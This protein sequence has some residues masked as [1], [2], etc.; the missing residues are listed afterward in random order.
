MNMDRMQPHSWRALRAVSEKYNIP[1]EKII[2]YSV[3][4][5]ALG[6]PDWL[7]RK[8][9]SALGGYPDHDYKNLK[10]KI[11]HHHHGIS[12]E[13]IVVTNGASEFFFH[14]TRALERKVALLTEPSFDLYKKSAGLQK[15]D[16][17]SL[18]LRAEENFNLD[19][20]QLSESISKF[21]EGELMIFLGHPNLYRDLFAL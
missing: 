10:A 8:S 1:I 3:N 17:H 21:D 13:K 15:M 20:S 18:P 16:I 6:F 19:V 4:T 14:L 7:Q 11:A 5:N 12:P 2:D 9:L